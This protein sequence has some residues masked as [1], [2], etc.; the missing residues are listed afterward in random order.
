MGKK[1]DKTEDDRPFSGMDRGR[2]VPG[3]EKHQRERCKK[4]RKK[5]KDDTEESDEGWYSRDMSEIS[6]NSECVENS[7]SS[8]DNADK[9]ELVKTENPWKTN[10]IRRLL[11]NSPDPNN[12]QQVQ[13]FISHFLRNNVVRDRGTVGLTVYFSVNMPSIMTNKN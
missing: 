13:A 8:E 9:P 7:N 2:V 1:T 10:V 12:P 4:M 3:R 11:L 5:N 6:E